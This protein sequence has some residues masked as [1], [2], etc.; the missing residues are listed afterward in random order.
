MS[1]AASGVG[2]YKL[3]SV[4][5]QYPTPA[6]FEGLDRLD[7]E[8]AAIS[9]RESRA[10]VRAVPGLAAG[11]RA[12]RGRPA[13]RGDLRPAP[14]L[15][16]VPDLLPLRR[17][18]QAR[19]GDA[20]LQD[21]LPRRASSCPPMRSYRTTCRWC[22]SSPRSPRAGSRLLR[23]VRRD[24]ELLRRAL[25]QAETP[26]AHLVDAVCAQLPRLEPPA[27]WRRCAS[28]GSPARRTRTS[29]WSRSRRRSTSPG[30]LRA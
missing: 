4:L 23:S 15:R 11:H 7:A 13:L 30:S 26:Y 9:P 17:H 14:P 20:R 1:D 21:R 6:L 29:A 27:T 10:G 18:P 5:L 24:L 3:A 8:A 12:D 19:H 28:T 22:S 2:P 16:A 25:H